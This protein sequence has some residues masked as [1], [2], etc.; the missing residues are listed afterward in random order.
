MLEPSKT[1][2][3]YYRRRR[4]NQFKYLRARPGDWA[5]HPFQCDQCWCVN[6]YNRLP[7][8]NGPADNSALRV[9]RRA[10]LDVFWSRESRT[11]SCEV[12]GLKE[13]IRRAREGNRPI[14]LEKFTPWPLGDNEGMG[15]AMSMLD[16]SLEKGKINKGYIQFDTTRKLRS[17]ASNVYSAGAGAGA[18]ALKYSMKSH[19][20][21]V[22]HTY[23][24]PMQSIF[25]ERFT[26]GMKIRMPKETMRNK[27]LS[28]KVGELLNGALVGDI[29][30]VSV[31]LR[32]GKW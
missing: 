19:R 18:N 5:L 22:L 12:G 4:D 24:G 32:R 31:G 7:L 6:L 9:I 11:V 27:P 15:V 23:Q 16:K 13:L 26:L 20:G 1:S 3:K 21:E 10:N 8:A 17:A 29:V 14:P 25:M 30:G 28:S 2:Q